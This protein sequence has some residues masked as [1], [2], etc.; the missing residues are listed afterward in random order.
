MTFM[1]IGLSVVVF[2]SRKAGL[3]AKT[4]QEAGTC[5]SILQAIVFGEAE[6]R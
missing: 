3:S 1:R 5:F 6:H 4:R 2:S